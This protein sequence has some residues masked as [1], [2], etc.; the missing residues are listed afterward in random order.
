MHLCD[1]GIDDGFFD[2]TRD[3]DAN[4]YPA[5]T[6]T[7]HAKQRVHFHEE[8]S[9]REYSTPSEQD[10]ERDGETDPPEFVPITATCQIGIDKTVGQL[11][12]QGPTIEITQDYDHLQLLECTTS[13]LNEQS[14]SDSVMIK[15]YYTDGSYMSSQPDTAAWSCVII[16]G[17]DDGEEPTVFRYAGHKSNKMK[18]SFHHDTVQTISSS[19]T[20]ELGGVIWALNMILQ[21]PTGHYSHIHCDSEVAILHVYE[22]LASTGL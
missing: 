4:N 1:A 19:T 22:L 8:D 5:R 3:P 21:E 7:T 11:L 14:G 16:H 17:Y 10:E 2:Y 12:R 15:H 6:P 9:E 13:A 18:T 20:V